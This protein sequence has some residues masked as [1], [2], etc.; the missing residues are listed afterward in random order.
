MSGEV[1]DSVTFS[2]PG[3]GGGR[4]NA[5]AR[6]AFTTYPLTCVIRV[7]DFAFLPRKVPMYLWVH[8]SIIFLAE[9]VS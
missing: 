9:L 7:N 4:R 2:L 3:D 5:R 1:E 6:P 8:Q